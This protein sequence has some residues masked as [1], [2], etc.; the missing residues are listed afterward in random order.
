MAFASCSL[1]FVLFPLILVIADKTSDDVW[2][3]MGH[4]KLKDPKVVALAKF[5]LSEHNKKTNTTRLHFVSIIHGTTQTDV[6]YSKYRLLIFTTNG[7]LTGRPT[8]YNAV[9]WTM[10]N[11]RFILKSFEPRQGIEI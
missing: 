3:P 9:V 4:K 1:L 2:I 7:N 5:A 10:N 8:N 11:S 6:R